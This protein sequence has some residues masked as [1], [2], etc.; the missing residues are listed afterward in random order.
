[1]IGT[2]E[3]IKSVLDEYAD[4]QLNIASDEARVSLA[5]DI[6]DALVLRE[7]IALA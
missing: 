7:N 2:Q 6:N 1:M 3:T 4:T 5:K